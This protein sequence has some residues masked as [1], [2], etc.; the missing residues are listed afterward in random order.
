MTISLGPASTFCRLSGIC[1]DA[2]DN[3]YGADSESTSN[4]GR[5]P[6]IRIGNAATGH[7]AGRR[8][9][10]PRPGSIT[11]LPCPSGLFWRCRA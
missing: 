5:R 2:D 1:I 6:G 9:A 11:V 8:N 3:I 4:P 7:V 10:L